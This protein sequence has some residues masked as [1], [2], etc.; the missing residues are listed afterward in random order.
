MSGAVDTNGVREGAVIRRFPP[1]SIHRIAPVSDEVAVIHRGAW[2]TYE[3][4]DD[5]AEQVLAE[6]ARRSLAKA[7]IRD[8]QEQQRRYLAARQLDGLMGTPGY[9]LAELQLGAAIVLTLA[10]VLAAVLL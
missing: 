4:W 8:A 1:W 5:M 9:A 6:L 3:T 2:R 7:R 10:P